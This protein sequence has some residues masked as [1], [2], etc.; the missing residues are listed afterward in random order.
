MCQWLEAALPPT[1]VKAMWLILLISERFFRALVEGQRCASFETNGSQ[2]YL[3][4]QLLRPLITLISV[5]SGV[6]Q[7]IVRDSP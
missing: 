1:L 7:L 3:S 4:M 6:N 2:L 5:L